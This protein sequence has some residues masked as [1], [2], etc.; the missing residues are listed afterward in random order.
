MLA[1]GLVVNSSLS[2]IGGATGP[3][4]I[5][6]N[7]PSIPGQSQTGS[8][9]QNP[10]RNVAAV[11]PV[12]TR[13]FVRMTTPVRASVTAAITD[14]VYTTLQE[15]DTLTGA[16]T[17]VANMPENPIFSLFGA[18]RTA[19]PPRQMAVDASGTVYA[20]TLSGLSVVPTTPT[21]TATQ[22]QIAAKGGVVNA[23]DGSSNFAPG[24]FIK[25]SGTNLASTA[26]AATT[27]APTVLGGSCALL[28]GVPLPLLSTG[29]NQMVAQIPTTLLGGS[30]VLQIR[31]LANAQ[32][33]SSMVVSLQK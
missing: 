28:D 31:S 22:P 3:G 12:D 4:L 21:T 7:P 23:N 8:V 30:N 6:V 5:P 9:A 18:T 33:S 2:V 29:P 1:N 26:T 25:I 11:A 32:R 19:V 24:S 13:Y 16:T 14:S 27:P 20:L 17:T 15:V 10:L